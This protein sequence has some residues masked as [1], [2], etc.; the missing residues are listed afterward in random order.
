MLKYIKELEDYFDMEVRFQE[1]MGIDENCVSVKSQ[2][3][4]EIGEKGK[5]FTPLF[6]VSTAEGFVSVRGIRIIESVIPYEGQWY[7]YELIQDM[8][9]HGDQIRFDYGQVDN[10]SGII[11]NFK[12]IK[13]VFF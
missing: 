4:P 13:Q 1:E 12:F 5:L 2:I 8:R 11:I 9:A 3:E 10:F 6:R 7:D